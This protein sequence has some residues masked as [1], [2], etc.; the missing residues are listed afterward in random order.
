MCV[1][2]SNTYKI[3]FTNLIRNYESTHEIAFI[4]ELNKILINFGFSVQLSIS[5][6]SQCVSCTKDK[7]CVLLVDIYKNSVLRLCFDDLIK[8]LTL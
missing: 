2:Y 1:P 4:K 3:L 6:I 5:T 7:E 8:T